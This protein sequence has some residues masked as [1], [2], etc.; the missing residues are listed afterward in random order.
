[1]AV[2]IDRT[3]YNAL[4]DDDGTNTKGTPWSKNQVKIVLMDPIDGALAKVLPLTGGS[5]TGIVSITGPVTIA[6]G[7]NATQ[8]TG[9]P[10]ALDFIHTSQPVGSKALRVSNNGTSSFIYSMNETNGQPGG[11]AINLTLDRAGGVQVGGVLTVSGA[12]THIVSA[13]LPGNLNILM[14]R[15]TAPGTSGAALYLGN[16]TDSG[17]CYLQSN[18]S[19]YPTNVYLKAGGA[20]LAANGPGGL[21]FATT[22]AAASVSIWTQ[23]AERMRIESNGVVNIG[24]TNPLGSVNAVTSGGTVFSAQNLSGGNSCYY[25]A[26]YNSASGLAGVIQQLSATTVAF[27]SASDHRLKIDLGPASDLTALRGVIVH[28]FTWKKDGTRDRGVFSQEAHAH[29]PRANSPGTDELTDD[30]DLKQPWMTDYSK[31][32]SDLI[33][34]WQQH[35]AAIAALRAELLALKG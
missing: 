12:G 3:N 28:D 22:N 35:D 24:T 23:Y 18:A 4:I 30:G 25:A 33:V 20:V 17:S 7:G 19:N 5:I 1:M 32:V 29:Y 11:G 6:Q 13:N 26:F 9:T 34:G 2:T 15:N 21:N 16:D 8:L 27:S 31:F 10:P 14:V